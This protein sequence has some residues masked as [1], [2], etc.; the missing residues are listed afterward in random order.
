MR[1]HLQCPQIMDERAHSL[2]ALARS[3]NC[4]LEVLWSGGHRGVLQWGGNRHLKIWQVCSCL[5]V[6]E[7]GPPSVPGID[8][9]SLLIAL[10][11]A[12]HPHW[13]PLRE[14]ALEQGRELVDLT[15]HEF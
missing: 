1:Q 7:A 11:Q 5:K 10:L 13:S 3:S 8:S 4:K 15:S 14:S 12:L 2:L 6:I 9:T